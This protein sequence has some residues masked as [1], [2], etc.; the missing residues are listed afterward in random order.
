MPGECL[1]KDYIS[2]KY[3]KAIGIPYVKIIREKGKEYTDNLLNDIKLLMNKC[4]I[5]IPIVDTSRYN[6]ILVPAKK[7]IKTKKL[8]K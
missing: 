3:V 1:V 8:N 7:E 6:Q 5:S 4:D 2:I